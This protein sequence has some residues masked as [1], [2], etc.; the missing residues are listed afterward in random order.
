MGLPGLRGDAPGRLARQFAGLPQLLDA[1]ARKEALVALD[2]DILAS[3]T[4]RTNEARLRTIAAALR[5]W[6]IPM[7][8]LFSLLG[9]R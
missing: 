6:G 3:T 9:K 7:W 4:Q 5:L 8:P 2:R 1:D